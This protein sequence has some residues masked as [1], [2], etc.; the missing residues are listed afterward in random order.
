M[1]QEPRR[2]ETIVFAA[3]VMHNLLISRYPTQATV[4]V[5]REDPT[6]HNIIPG[7]WRDDNTLVGLDKIG[8]N[9][10]LKVAKIQRN[11]LCKYYSSEAGSVAWQDKMI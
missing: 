9:T 8:G 2:V 3:C 4:D 10:S 11:Y 7:A 5:D 6:T 1:Q